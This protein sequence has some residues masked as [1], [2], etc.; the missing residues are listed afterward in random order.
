MRTFVTK[1]GAEYDSFIECITAKQFHSD[2][3]DSTAIIEFLTFGSLYGSKT[4]FSNVS[5]QTTHQPYTFSENHGLKNSPSVK[6][7]SLLKQPPIRLDEAKK[8]FFEFFDDRKGWLKDK[9]ISVDLTGGIDSRM[10]AAI[11]IHLNIPFEAVFSTASGSGAELKIVE[12][13]AEQKDIPLKVIS[14]PEYFTSK[15]EINKL[16]ALG[17]G[18]WD[19]TGLRSLAETQKWREEMGYDLA[20]TG[21]GGELFK[22][23]WWQQDFPMYKKEKPDF[24]RLIRMRMYPAEVSAEW[25]GTVFHKNQSEYLCRFK[26]HLSTYTESTNTETYDQVYYHLRIK[27]QISVLS[28]ASANFL[29]VW[30]P[31]LEPE[32]L[33]IGYNLRRRAR[34][35]DRFHRAVI[36]EYVPALSDIP[37]T[38]GGMTVSDHPLNIASD[39][40]KFVR[41][42]SGR[43]L[44]KLRKTRN[45]QYNKSDI[46]PL[47][48]DEVS[49]SIKK[50]KKNDILSTQAPS[51]PELYSLTLHGRLILLGYLCGMIES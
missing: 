38:G 9:K 5:K 33:K 42:K 41:H 13:L 17:D 24:D 15:N 7:N 44:S 43:V 1:C 31:L 35:L 3:L 6:E 29:P 4:F 8:R 19:P 45:N 22:D 37:T 11:L 28:H 40:I 21:V 50:L 2:D 27:E 14:L 10:V 18:M 49:N 12:K 36:S 39:I 20:I 32:L 30:S 51:E 25:L 46:D 26:A 16:I 48:Y 47:I 23:F 34:F